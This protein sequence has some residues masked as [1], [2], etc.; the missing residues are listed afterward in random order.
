MLMIALAALN[1]SIAPLVM[2]NKN[3]FHAYVIWNN[4]QNEYLREKILL[5]LFIFTITVV[6]LRQQQY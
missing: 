6:K 3:F 5:P 2:M 4:S 1:I